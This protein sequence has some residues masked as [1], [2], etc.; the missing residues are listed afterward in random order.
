MRRFTIL[1]VLALLFTSIAPLS[2]A[3]FAESNNAPIRLKVATF[4]PG[5]GEKP[6]IPPGLTIASPPRSVP[7]Y[8]LVQ[9][10]GPIQP[11]WKEELAAL[12]AEI[13]E[14][15]PEFAFKVRMTPNIA[16]RARQLDA[17]TW[18]G[19][20]QPAYKI[21]PA[22]ANTAD[23]LRV[24]LTAA[25]DTAAV[26]AEIAALGGTVTKGGGR[27]LTV[28]LDPQQIPAL[29][30]LTEVA[31]IEAE[32]EFQ[33]YNNIARL[34]GGGMDAYPM[35]NLG[36]FGAGQIAAAA[37]TGLD[38]NNPDTVHLDFR[39]RVIQVDILGS[40]TT[41]VDGHGTHTS[42][43]ILGNGTRSGA[44]AA[45]H[46]Y[47]QNDSTDPNQT[48]AK[49]TGIAPEAQYYFQAIASRRGQQIT[50][51]GLPSD[52][53]QLFQAPYNAGARVHSNSWGSSA[54]GAYTT[55]S[56]DV[57]EFMWNNPDMLVTTSAGNAG[58][59]ANNDGW[60][61]EDSMGSPA[62]AKNVLSVGATENARTNGGVNPE[63]TS[64]DIDEVQCTSG[65]AWG[66]CWPTDFDAPP[67][68]TDPI[69]GTDNHDQMAAFSSRGPTDDGRIKPD[70]VAPGTNI[71]S[72][73]SSYASD[74]GWG[75]GPDD[76]YC[77]MGG[78]SM[79]NPLTAGAAVLVQDWYEDIKGHA[80]P[81]AAL[82]KATL[83]NTAVD[84]DGYGDS[85]KEAGQPIPNSHEGWGRVNLGNVAADGREFYDGASISTGGTAAYTF[86]V[87][88][89]QPF[90]VSLVW[91][92]YPAST[93]AAVA[94]VNDLD[95]VVSGPGGTFYGNV[96]SGG[97][98]QTGGSAD[99]INNVENAY[100]QSAAAGTWT[101]QV[102]GFNTPYGPQPFA[103]VVDGGGSSGG[104]NQ[105]PTAAFTYTCTGLDCDFTDQS[106][107]SDG[108]I[109]TWY[110]DFGDG[111]TSTAQNPSHTYAADGTYD[112]TLTVTDDDSATD[113]DTQ[114]VTVSGGGGGDTMHVAAID[115]SFTKAGVNRVVYTTVTIVD[116]GGAP[117][118]GATVSLQM[119]LPSNKL[120]TGSAATGADGTVTFSIKSKETGTYTSTV[121]NVTHPSLTYDDSANVETFDTLNVY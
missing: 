97:W 117:V 4:H 44:S 85:T 92:D 94:L 40:L 65:V 88:G 36:I 58:I 18:V 112:V 79:A 1:V 105:P 89:G 27:S 17:V 60:V 52:L 87:S 75:D 81:S 19:I 13:A 47:G 23:L 74:C 90:K 84:I 121:T 61:D 107:D 6:D 110:W 102:K 55:S 48:S 96:F 30:H 20:F 3:T 98:S 15:I 16:G 43:S 53:N 46:D 63:D 39:G 71:L 35:W 108:T 111:N 54:A 116:E 100:I 62:T 12:G 80:N 68:G 77:M 38:T 66:D 10:E 64:N 82:V 5:L 93:T 7:T 101:V 24:D 21:S 56:Q 50:L 42:G 78:T 106:T 115:M 37:D 25:A 34:G 45:A 32:P 86:D 31:W 51:G 104:E 114:A 33:F 14:Y 49:V 26:R 11:A 28:L 83:I 72:T 9:F 69:G 29:A 95:L 8:Y 113:D 118:S 109:D 22:L 59:D 91:S 67:T 103:L 99:R 41:D 76:Y 57:D 2:P 120:A 70:V 119:T 73:K